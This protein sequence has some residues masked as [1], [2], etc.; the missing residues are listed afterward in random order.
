MFSHKSNKTNQSTI[1]LE[2]SSFQTKIGLAGMEKPLINM[3]N[4]I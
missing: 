2:I 4:V 3:E 1:V